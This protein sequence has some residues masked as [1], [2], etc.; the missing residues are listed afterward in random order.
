MAKKRSAPPPSK[1]VTAERA[2]RLYHLVRLVAEG[3]LTRSALMRR[4]GLDIRGFY[5]D[6]ELLREA[7]VSFTLER[8]RYTLQEDPDEATARLPFPDPC[9]TL[10]EAAQLARGRSAAHRRMQAL[11]AQLEKARGRG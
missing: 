1:S 2:A 7:G 11:L 4:L 9:L 10:G 8:Q 5:R 3:P 6:L